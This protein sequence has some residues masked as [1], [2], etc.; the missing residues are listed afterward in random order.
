MKV[1][2]FCLSR[3]IQ[4]LP[5]LIGITLVAFLLLRVMPGDPATLMLGSRGTPEVIARLNEQLG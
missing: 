4:L 2:F 5:V 3:V 1:V